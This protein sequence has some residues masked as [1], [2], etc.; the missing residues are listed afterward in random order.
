MSVPESS[1][2]TLPGKKNLSE[3]VLA[4]YDQSARDLPWRVRGQGTGRA[5]TNE[6]YRIWLAEIMLQQTTVKAVIPYFEKFVT[7]WPT[8]RKLAAASEF[9][10]VTAWAGL[11]YYA[12]ARNLHACA[13]IVVDRYDGRFPDTRS[14][15]LQLP[16]IGH[17]TAAA[18]AAIGFQRCETV[19]DG[20]VERVMARLHKVT[21][22]FPQARR[23]IR[24]LART[25]TTAHRPGDYAQALMDLGAT[26]CRPRKPACPVC[27]CQDMCGA[28]ASGLQHELPM[29]KRAGRRPTR[30]GL[31]YVGRRRDGAWLLER[32]PRKGL[33]GG[34]LGWPGSEWVIGDPQHSPPC[35]GRWRTVEGVVRHDFTHFRLHLVVLVAELPN[36]VRPNAGRFVA[37]EAF[38][39]R[40]L[41]SLM[42]KVAEH[43]RSDPCWLT[44]AGRSA[45]RSEAAKPA[46]TCGA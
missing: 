17:Y 29:P 31:V 19:V 42:R 43:A 18:I 2:S 33:L 26:I 10:I 14:E 20:N 21:E 34:T 35:E 13:R 9:E 5:S 41:P 46:S 27:P 7:R 25:H 44:T 24:R 15:L 45:D 30:E 12:R 28:W 4:W 23:T 36:S 1:T 16:G 32:R 39:C 40:E 22:P 3:V 37:P 6:I 8:I 11:G 38:D